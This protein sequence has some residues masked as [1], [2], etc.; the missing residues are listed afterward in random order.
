MKETFIITLQI[1][2]NSGEMTNDQLD[3]HGLS[4]RYS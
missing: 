4:L 2:E 3:N 1:I